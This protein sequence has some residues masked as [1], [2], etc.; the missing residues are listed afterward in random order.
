M[1]SIVNLSLLVLKI[2]DC[3]IV[4]DGAKNSVSTNFIG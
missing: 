1:S 4:Q 2:Q 3:S